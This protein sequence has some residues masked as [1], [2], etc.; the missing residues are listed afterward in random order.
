MTRTA[1]QPRP[2]A[3]ARV[4][5]SLSFALLAAHFYRAGILPGVG[6]GLLLLPLPW[7]ARPWA[8]R[9]A[10]GALLLGAAEWVRT[11][12][13]FAAQ[14]QAEGRPV[15]RLVLILGSVA[16]LTGLSALLLSRRAKAK[17]PSPAA[18]PVGEAA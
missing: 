2:P 6:A 4:L 13:L 15:L 8:T 5:A 3:A 12:V 16:L 7:L 14:R 18:G 17:L 9:T 1:P 10:Q 11:L